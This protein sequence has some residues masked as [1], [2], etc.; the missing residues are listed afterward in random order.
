[1][2]KTLFCFT[3]FFI[4]ILTSAEVN[5][6]DSNCVFLIMGGKKEWVSLLPGL[7]T[8]ISI[9][10]DAAVKKE[11]ARSGCK[12]ITTANDSEEV[13]LAKIKELKKSPKGATF[14]LAF[15]DHG[16]PAGPKLNDSLLV[17]G[18]GEYIT[19]GKF[20][21][22]L[23][24]N[25]PKGS[26]VSFQTNNCWPHLSEALIENNTEG[27][28]EMCGGSS[29]IPEQMSWNLHRIYTEDDGTLAGPYGALG[30][31][32]AN[33]YKKKN[34][35]N[36]SLQE[37]HYHAKKGDL[38]NLKR[39]PGLTTSVSFAQSVVQKKSKNSLLKT[40]IDDLLLAI[41]WK[42]D[43]ALEK[44][45]KVDK[46]SLENLTEKSIDGTCTVY[47]K[48]PFGQFLKIIAPLQANLVNTNFLN[49]PAPISSQ[50]IAAQKWMKNNSKFLAKLLSGIA[51]EKAQFIKKH[52]LH[53]KEKYEKIEKL[54]EELTEKHSMSL[55]DYEFNLRILQEGKLVQNFMNVASNDEK[56]RFSNFLTCETKPIY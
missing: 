1:M 40:D 19:Y 48:D 35:K 43:A 55:R 16:A 12:I 26:H 47:S 9:D 6:S 36:P 28:F 33:E 32:F 15:T 49:L 25:I 42:N 30:L 22:A 13:F 24:E 56:K 50:S 54:W 10:V 41:N 4:T 11:A 17:T 52:K 21:A 46:K 34:G 45:L 51:M 53:P 38:G 27:Q 5:A 29:T 2:K 8:D 31:R 3:L 14:H 37:F 23:K 44:F 18:P 7:S 39:Q 20:F